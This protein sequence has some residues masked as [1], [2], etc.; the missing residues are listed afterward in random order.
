[1][2]Y[3]TTKRDEIEEK[4][5]QLGG[6]RVTSDYGY[7][8]VK[9]KGKFKILKY[10]EYRCRY[11]LSTRITK[12]LAE[13]KHVFTLSIFLGLLRKPCVLYHDPKIDYKI[14]PVKISVVR[15]HLF[16]LKM[17]GDVVV[18]FEN[19][20]V[21]GEKGETVVWRWQS[22]PTD[23]SRYKWEK[24]E[25]SADLIPSWSHSMVEDSTGVLLGQMSKSTDKVKKNSSTSVSVEW[26]TGTI[27]D[28][29][30]NLLQLF[31]SGSVT[32]RNG[33]DVTASYEWL[34]S[35]VTD[36]RHIDVVAVLPVE[37]VEYY[38]D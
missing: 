2:L 22:C 24:V 25:G 27:W 3:N 21:E 38:F 17:D 15:C 23:E 35:I 12:T 4:I 19:K 6:I 26:S 29:F 33:F 34:G 32:T 9:R 14:Y 8:P 28:Y 5:R 31:V 10:D 18:K 7:I 13:I 36:S 37:R 16:S 1:M 11:C 20:S 30:W